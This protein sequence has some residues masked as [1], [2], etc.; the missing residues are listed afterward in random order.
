LLLGRTVDVKYVDNEMQYQLESGNVFAIE[1]DVRPWI[2]LDEVLA[3]SR[4]KA[5]RVQRLIRSYSCSGNKARQVE[6]K[7]G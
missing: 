4:A 6:I 2:D 7:N 1:H 3:S 5:E